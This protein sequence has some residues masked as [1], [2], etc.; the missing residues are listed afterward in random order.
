MELVGYTDRI[1]IAPGD[2]LRCMVSCRAA[3]YSASLVRL[4]HGDRNPRGPGAK[5]YAVPSAIDGI[6][7]GTEQL[8]R[9]GS[10][11]VVR[12]GVPL[13]EAGNLGLVLWAMPALDEHRACTLVCAWRPGGGGY[14][15][16]LDDGGRPTL[17]LGSAGGEEASIALSRPLATRAWHRLM[18]GFDAS[19][20][21]MSLMAAPAGRGASRPQRA[22]GAGVRP[23]PELAPVI[24]GAR[25]DG[26]RPCELF[27]GKLESP[28]V[29]E[30]P[31]GRADE[32]RLDAGAAPW[33]LTPGPIAAWNFAPHAGE[34]RFVDVVAGRDGTFVNQ[35]SRAVT[36]HRW[37]GE[38]L[39]FRSSPDEYAAVGF[40][41]DDL[42]DA[43]WDPSFSFTAPA[44]LGSGFYAIRLVTEDAVETLPFVVRPR[45]ASASASVLVLAPTLTYRAYANEHESWFDRRTGAAR[46]EIPDVVSSEDRYAAHQRLI[47]LYDHHRDGS[48]ATY[49]SLLRPQATMRPHLVMPALGVPHAL[50]ADLYLVDWLEHRQTPYDVVADEDLHE[51]GHQLLDRYAVVITGSHPEYWTVQ[52][53]DAL[54]AYVDTGGRL[55]YLGGNGFYW[56][57]SLAPGRPHVL[58]VRRGS[59]GTGP[60]HGEPGE[61]HHSSTGEPGGPWRFR[62]RAPQELTGVGFAAMG[63]GA[64]RPYERVPDV[65]ERA[66]FVFEGVPEDAAIGAAA[67]GLGAAAGVEIDRS[68]R[69]LGT[70]A[71]AVVLASATGFPDAYRP[72]SEDVTT[73]AS[74][75]VRALVRADMVLVEHPGGGAVFSV[76]SIGWCSALSH[77]AYRSEVS[78][79]TGNVLDHFVELGQTRG[80]LDTP[81][82][83]R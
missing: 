23:T 11:G 30:R 31:L 83:V 36:G 71:D 74:L 77:D 66:R 17:T 67:L 19:S 58:E 35:P 76:G 79:I 21:R 43:A 40:H 41:D 29:F 9:P 80:W 81:E 68:D 20:G 75:D 55:M 33:E 65:P 22:E 16:A 12:A 39:D 48:G 18:V 51:Q 78:R 10:Y 38:S 6:Y 50:A 13:G 32:Q 15:I 64:A 53:L 7:P 4:R 57:A 59:A 25:L 28:A 26:D 49:V 47:S 70:A 63:H 42:E 69:A 1:T 24:V 27:N 56:V 8:L 52:M 37:R 5:E 61:S 45:S 3:T 72:A 82:P 62:G 14:R 73:D 54:T 44:D 34:T 2:T 60:F 46:P